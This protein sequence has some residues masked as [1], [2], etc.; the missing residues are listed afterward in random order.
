M[1][2]ILHKNKYPMINISKKKRFKYYEV[3]QNAQY[4][5]NLKPFVKFLIG[6]L[7]KDNLKF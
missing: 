7:K 1:N 6:I 3:L 5:N 4:E 2:F